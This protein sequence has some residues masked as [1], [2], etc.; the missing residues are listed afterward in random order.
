LLPCQKCRDD[1]L[2][3]L[4]NS[5]PQKPFFDWS[6]N[7]HNSVNE[8]LGKVKFSLESARKNYFSESMCTSCKPK[9]TNSI[10]LFIILIIL[11]FAS[12]LVLY[13]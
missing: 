5:K 2:I 4:S 6:V 11:L 3:L 7:I 9:S 13:S 10:L 8:K 1:F 12:W